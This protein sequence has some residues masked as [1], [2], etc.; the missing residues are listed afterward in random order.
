MHSLIALFV[1]LLPMGGQRDPACDI[2]S[3]SRMMSLDF[4]KIQLPS[5][6]RI[7]W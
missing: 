3:E 5:P 1:K 6:L 4:L 2:R 7:G